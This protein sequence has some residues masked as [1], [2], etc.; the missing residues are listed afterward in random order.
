MQEHLHPGFTHWSGHHLGHTGAYRTTQH[1]TA[2]HRTTPHHTAPHHAT[3]HDTTPHHTTPHHTSAPFRLFCSRCSTTS[4][5]SMASR[6]ATLL[7]V[8]STTQCA[9]KYNQCW[10]RHCTHAHIPAPTL[11]DLEGVRVVAARGV[12]PLDLP[13]QHLARGVHDDLLDSTGGVD[14][15]RRL[16]HLRPI[17]RSGEGQAAT[18]TSVPPGSRF[19]LPTWA[20][21]WPPT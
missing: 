15:R 11:T 6:T 20:V 3:P 12:D 13:P 21:T 16:R 14:G 5:S 17:T 4:A 19:G 8:T 1:H 10:G 7:R 9:T 2:P 18:I